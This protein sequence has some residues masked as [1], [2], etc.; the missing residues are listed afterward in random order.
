MWF[1]ST[2]DVQLNDTGLEHKHQHMTFD[3]QFWYRSSYNSYTALLLENRA[4]EYN[5]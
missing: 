2:K 3:S 4:P 5:E 1:G